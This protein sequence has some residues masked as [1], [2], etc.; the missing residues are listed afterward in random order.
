MI[1]RA[2]KIGLQC[3]SHAEHPMPAADENLALQGSQDTGTGRRCPAAVEHPSGP[4]TGVNW[5]FLPTDRDRVS[6]ECPRIQLGSR[7]AFPSGQTEQDCG[8]VSTK[9]TR[10]RPT[11]SGSAHDARVA[12]NRHS[13][14]P[15][16]T[17][18]PRPKSAWTVR[19]R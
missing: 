5:L 3:T 4:P 12:L 16:W 11:P 19:A 6:F 15:T 10:S 1:C 18:V 2:P 7:E 13:L 17:R 8:R 14:P 9:T